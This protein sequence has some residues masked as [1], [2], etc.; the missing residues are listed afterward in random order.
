MSEC[1][2]ALVA[3]HDIDPAVEFA[4]VLSDYDAGTAKVEIK[5]KGRLVKEETPY[6][7]YTRTVVTP[8]IRIGGYVGQKYHESPPKY[9]PA[10][11]ARYATVDFDKMAD[12]A[13]DSR[14]VIIAVDDEGDGIPAGYE[15]MGWDEPM[16]TGADSTHAAMRAKLKTWTRN[17]SGEDEAEAV[18]NMLNDFRDDNP[19]FTP[20]QIVRRIRRFVS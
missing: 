12:I 18:G 15:N 9:P 8:G 11:I 1:K 13:A 14:V 2:V 20:A 17:N 7:R 4:E 5:Q 16:S 19:G 3:R 6:T 10:L